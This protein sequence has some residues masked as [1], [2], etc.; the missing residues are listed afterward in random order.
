MEVSAVTKYVKMSPTKARDLANEI[1]GLS[2]A[3]ALRITEFNARKAALQIG[4]TLKSAIANAENNHELSADELI[5]Q[6]AT[7]GDGPT[8]KRFKPRARGSAGAILKRSSHIFITLT[9]EFEAP[10]E[11]KTSGKAKKR[12]TIKSLFTGKAAAAVEEVSPANEQEEAELEVDKG[13]AE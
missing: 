8:L 1:K 3:E 12:D 5:V 4:K 6:E 10:E 2:V 9:D 13:S 11:K 7:I